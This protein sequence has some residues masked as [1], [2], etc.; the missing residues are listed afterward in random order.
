MNTRYSS[1]DGDANMASEAAG[2]WLCASTIGNVEREV[3][4]SARRQQVGGDIRLTSVPPAG[5]DNRDAGVR[6]GADVGTAE[7]AGA[8]LGFGFFR[9]RF[10]GTLAR[11]FG[12]RQ[13]AGGLGHHQALR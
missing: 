2:D 6:V 5:L 3:D 1:C 12:G 13:L 10:G 11:R 9:L 4:D 7:R 8:M